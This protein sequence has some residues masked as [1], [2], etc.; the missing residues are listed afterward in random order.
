MSLAVPQFG[1]FGGVGG[2]SLVVTPSLMGCGQLWSDLLSPTPAT[3]AGTHG[4]TRPLS[5]QPAGLAIHEDLGG[6]SRVR[7]EAHQGLGSLPGGLA[8]GHFC[9]G[10]S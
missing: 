8:Q 9:P 5:H 2:R 7:G 1:G 6:R 10:Q 4:L 3:L